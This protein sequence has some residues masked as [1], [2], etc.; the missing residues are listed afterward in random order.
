[1]ELNELPEA[2]V[3]HLEARQQRAVTQLPGL[4]RVD[5]ISI[6]VTHRILFSQHGSAVYGP[7]IL[8]VN[9]LVSSD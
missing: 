4:D 6:C 9:D 5:L 8:S 1:M 2:P 3:A 7:D